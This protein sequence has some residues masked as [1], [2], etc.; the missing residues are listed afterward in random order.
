MVLS[1]SSGKHSMPIVT[2]CI[3]DKIKPTYTTKIY[4]TEISKINNL[5]I[6]GTLMS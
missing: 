3:L 1:E 4:V 6:N 5:F 2:E